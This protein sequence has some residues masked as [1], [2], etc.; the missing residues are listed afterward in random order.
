MDQKTEEPDRTHLWQTDDSAK[1]VVSQEKEHTE[2][3]AGEKPQGH[4]ANMWDDSDMDWA[5]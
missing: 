1:Y 3:D 4:N 2:M 5:Q